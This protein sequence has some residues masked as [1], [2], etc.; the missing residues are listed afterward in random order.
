MLSRTEYM[1]WK[2]SESG[3][4]HDS[5]EREKVL[6]EGNELGCFEPGESGGRCPLETNFETP[7][8]I[9][10]EFLMESQHGESEGSKSFE[11][12]P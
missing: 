2:T 7:Y 3:V 4:M 9:I 8:C 1:L 5:L 12:F 6:Q 10:T 11:T